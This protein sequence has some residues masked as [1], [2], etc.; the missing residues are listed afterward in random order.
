MYIAK[1]N[2]WNREQNKYDANFDYYI[3]YYIKCNKQYKNSIMSLIKI[4]LLIKLVCV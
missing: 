4:N 2:T 1:K 3:I